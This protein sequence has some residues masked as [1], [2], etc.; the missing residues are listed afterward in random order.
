MRKHK[1]IQSTIFFSS[2]SVILL[3]KLEL[4]FVFYFPPNMNIPADT[5]HLVRQNVALG[6]HTNTEH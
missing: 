4:Q 6:K 2:A 3:G 1:F 5:L